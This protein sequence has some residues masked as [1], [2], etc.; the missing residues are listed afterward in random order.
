MFM[1]MYNENEHGP[2]EREHEAEVE[3]VPSFIL[4]ISAFSFSRI[5]NKSLP[6][7]LYPANI[8]SAKCG[9]TISALRFNIQLL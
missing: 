4:Y 1:C 5:F 3:L 6:F 7:P 8:D 9:Y 2:Q